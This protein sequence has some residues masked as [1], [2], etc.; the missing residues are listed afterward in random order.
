[1]ARSLQWIKLFVSMLNDPKMYRISDRLW[2]RAVECF[3]L[4]GMV[5]EKGR[6]PAIDDIAHYLRV[7]RE[8]LEAE[9]VDLQHQGILDV[10][11]GRWVVSNFE[12][13]QAGAPGTVRW[14][15]WRDRQGLANP[16]S[17][18]RSNE[19]Q[20]VE[21]RRGETELESEEEQR[22]SSRRKRGGLGGREA[23]TTTTNSCPVCGGV[24]THVA[25]LDADG[26]VDTCPIGMGIPEGEAVARFGRMRN[27]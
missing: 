6:L 25:T 19:V 15:N 4:A 11:G 27:P 16:T 9:L 21:K 26:E 1:M 7:E 17:Q 12:K 3:L 24:G 13:W 22:R 5:A 23:T 8:T 10:R 18:R 2:R 20:T 14:R